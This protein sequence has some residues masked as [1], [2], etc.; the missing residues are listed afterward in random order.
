M[1]AGLLAGSFLARLIASMLFEVRPLDPVIFTITPVFLAMI[2]L[3]ACYLP[4]RRVASIDP[5]VVLRYE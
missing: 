4:A 5:V 1:G 2:A 3:L